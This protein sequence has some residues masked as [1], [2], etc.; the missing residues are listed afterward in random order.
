M[1]TIILT[2]GAGTYSVQDQ[3]TSQMI[4]GLSRIQAQALFNSTQFPF[5]STCL[6]ELWDQI[7][8]RK[9]SPELVFG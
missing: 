6:A 9:F 3:D 4:S 2:H 5:G 7:K 1:N 8:D